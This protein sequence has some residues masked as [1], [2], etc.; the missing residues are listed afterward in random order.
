MAVENKYVIV[1]FKNYTELNKKINE[2]NSDGWEVVSMFDVSD[3]E[4]KKNIL[5]RKEGG[6]LTDKQILND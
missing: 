1:N 5:L 3:N 2:L 4:N 6:D